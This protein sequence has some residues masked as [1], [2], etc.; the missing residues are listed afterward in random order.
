MNIAHTKCGDVE[1]RIEGE[2][3]EVALVLL[4][5]HVSASSH[6]GEDYFM[7]RGYQVLNVSRPGYGKTPLSTGTTPDGFA[8]ALSELLQQL[9]I[10]QVVV[11]GISAGGR[12]AMRL[13]AKYPALVSKLVLQSSVSFAPWPDRLI[14]FGS[15]LAF[16]SLSEKYVWKV[17]RTLLKRN[18]KS[19]VT[20]M[21]SNMTTLD[22]AA[23]VSSYSEKQIQELVHLFAQM[24]SGHGFINDLVVTRGDATDVS[25]PTLIIHSKY[26]KSVPLSHPRLLAQQIRNSRL[27]LSKAESHMLWFSP[28]YQEIKQVMNE[29]LNN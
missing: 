24:R 3:T 25:V 7:E 19:A 18:P 12:T 26:D 16:N 21:L 5:G 22:P 13:A 27:F 2:G 28:H 17:I 4:G 15:H 9:G 14:K 6:L 8:D 20:M 1:Y 10:K 29:F 11:V 23:V